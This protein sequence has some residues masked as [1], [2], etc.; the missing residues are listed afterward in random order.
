MTAQA[1]GRGNL[2]K[3]LAADQLGA[4]TGQLALL[5]L[6]VNQKQGFGDHQSQHGVAQELQALII[7]RTGGF[8]LAAGE[9]LFAGCPLVG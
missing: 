8:D 3:M 2:G 5:P 7:A 6:R 1:D 4:D 9:R